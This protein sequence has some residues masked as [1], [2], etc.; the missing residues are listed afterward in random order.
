MNRIT[1]E[2]LL[3]VDVPAAV[4]AGR[5]SGDPLVAAAIQ[6]DRLDVLPRSLTFL[7]EVVR[8]GGIGFAADLPE[9]MPTPEQSALASSWLAAAA[10]NDEIRIARWLDAVAAVLEARRATRLSSP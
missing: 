6:A 5:L 7:A 3:D 10:G 9:P 8:R 1:D 4:A 2:Q